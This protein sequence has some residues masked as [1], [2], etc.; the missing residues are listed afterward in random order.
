MAK[1][2]RDRYRSVDGKPCI[3]VR[4]KSALQLFDAK[5][6]SP[7]I[8][9]DLDDDFAEYIIT[10]AQDFS[11]NVHL[12]I[13][14]YISE[15]PSTELSRDSILQAIREY[16]IYQ[17]DLKR[18][19]LSKIFKTGQF[20]LIVG[21]IFLIACLTIAQLGSKIP[22]ENFSHF[23]KEGFTIFGWVS[24]WKPLELIL[25]DWWPLYDRIK[26]FGRLL[27]AEYEIVYEVPKNQ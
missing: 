26:L 15:K 12:K 25:F 16:F 6:P 18:K 23:V 21:L 7:F 20:F 5:D 1:K 10:S 4:V 24:M 8:E 13:L 11:S 19:Q 2:K 17:Q 14:I 9:R 27:Q 22:N 3:E